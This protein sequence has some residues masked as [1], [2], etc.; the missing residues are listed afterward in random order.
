MSELIPIDRIVVK[1]GRRAVRDV[2]SLAENI[3]EHGRLLHPITVTRELVLVAGG[4]RLAACRLL[5]WVE[6]PAVVL[7]VDYL[8]AKLIEIDENLHRQELTVLER[9][10]QLLQRKQ[11]YEA[12]H[13][14]TKHGGAPGLAGGGKQTKGERV[15]SFADDTASQLG[16]TS[17]TIQHET[18]IAEQIVPVVKDLIRET[19]LAD[20]KTEL[21]ELARL[22]PQHQ[23][24]VVRRIL[25][26]RAATVAAAAWAEKRESIAALP[27]APIVCTGSTVPKTLLVDARILPGHALDILRT[28]PAESVHCC[29]T[30]PPFWRLRHYDTPP[31]TWGDGWSG[32][33]GQESTPEPFVGHLVE[34]F[35]EVRRVLRPDGVCVVN[36]GDTYVGSWGNQG[37]KPERGA[38]RPVN[39]PMIQNVRPGIYPVGTRTGSIPEGSTLKPKDQ[40]G[41]PFRFAM[42][43]QDDGWWWRATIPWIKRNG[44]VSSVDDRPTVSHEYWLLF[45]R[46]E[47]YFWDVTATRTPQKTLGERHEGRSGY[48]DGHPSQGGI[49]HR[50]LHSDGANRRTGDWMFDSID[51]Q[52][53]QW[54]QFLADLKATR[55][56]G[57]GLL[58]DP[59]GDPLA[60]FANVVGTPEQHYASYP[61]RLVEPFIKAGTSEA[62]CCPRCL[63]PWERVVEKER[64][65]TRPG[66]ATTLAGVASSH[67]DSPYQGHGGSHVGNR[68][69]GRHVTHIHTRG[70][71]PSCSCN[72]GD[73]IPCTVLDPFAGSGVTGLVAIQLGCS[74]V[75]IELNPEYVDIA[76]RRIAAASRPRP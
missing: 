32:E 4:R 22:A 14:E 21:L 20:H 16:T 60:I 37:R 13:P 11:I 3:Q 75:G 59:E 63:A 55:A 15:S 46:S 53:E 33:L 71:E 58:S 52:I 29:I 26:G 27:R 61:P 76:C 57:Q 17:R 24:P 28:L 66:A 56:G 31:Q 72:A 41:V 50:E 70:W 54:D 1:P 8:D 43:M 25:A 65:P 42:A 38:Q 6:I 5:G 69:P 19:P 49:E 68:D 51:V 35:R 44:M 30:S 40:A 34:V 62:G 18:Q 23:A 9:S 10:E 7:D 45:A 2:E 74:F 67:G 36:L 48:R 73:P 47:R 39:G 12:R 64:V